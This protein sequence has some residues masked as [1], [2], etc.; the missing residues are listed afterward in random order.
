M[1][2]PMIEWI[3]KKLGWDQELIDTVQATWS[4]IYTGFVVGAIVFMLINDSCE[5]CQ[6]VHPPCEGIT[7]ESYGLVGQVTKKENKNTV[8]FEDYLSVARNMSNY[9]GIG[10]N[11]SEGI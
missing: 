6:L 9:Q 11:M 3:G 10:A 7:Y 2:G 5:I 8:P 4:G 1:L